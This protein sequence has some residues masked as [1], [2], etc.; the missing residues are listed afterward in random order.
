MSD[1]L[2]PLL[3]VID[4]EVDAFWCFAGYIDMV[5]SHTGMH[6]RTSHDIIMHNVH[7]RAHAIT[8]IHC[9]PDLD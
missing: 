5:V 9:I 1:L 2:A 6:I 8:H 4:S 7:M 3:A